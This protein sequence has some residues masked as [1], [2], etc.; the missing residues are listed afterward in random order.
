MEKYIS[1]NHNKLIFVILSGKNNKER[2]TILKQTWLKNLKFPYYFVL[3]EEND[4]KE[5]NILQVPVKDNDLARKLL[6]AYKYLLEQFDFDY[7][8]TCDDDTYVVVD[9]LLKCGYE[10][11]MFMGNFYTFQEGERKNL[12]HAEGGAG[13]FLDYESISR[14]TQC[15]IEH[16][17]L[18]Q[19][20]DVAISDLASMY[21]VRIHD[22]KRFV[23]GYSTK[24]RHGEIPTP[25]NDKITS[26][27]IPINMFAKI[28]SKFTHIYW[29]DKLNNLLKPT[30]LI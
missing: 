7:I 9:R 24:K 21:S 15:P 27:Y 1:K 23:Q 29:K 16:K 12:F 3:G 20:S 28:H 6:S 18:D 30:A 13:F 22:D 2:R 5:S 14:I 19:P 25:H 10:N 8:F 11:H 4:S 17:I 26:H